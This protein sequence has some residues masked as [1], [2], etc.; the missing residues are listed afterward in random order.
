MRQRFK[1]IFARFFVAAACLLAVNMAGCSHPQVKADGTPE[2]VGIDE[3][4]SQGKRTM[5]IAAHPDDECFSGSILARSSIHYGNPLHMVV[6]TRGDGGECGLPGGCHPDTATVR[7]AEM[8]KVV[9]IYKSGLSQESFFN[10]PLP[11]ESFPKRHE[12]YERWKEHRDPVEYLVQEIRKFKP[13]VVFT[14]EPT[15][16]GTGHPEHQLVSR[17]ATT[18]IRQAADPAVSGGEPHKVERTYF[19][20]NRF[21]LFRMLGAAD[22]GPVSEVFDA[23]LPA[24]GKLS[25]VDFMAHA[26]TFHKTQANDMGTVRKGRIMFNNLPLRRVDPFTQSWD[27]AEKEGGK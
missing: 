8:Q 3:F 16:G 14:F 19:M 10:A 17:L 20:L 4:L 6:M 24:T 9:E 22:P 13:D 2:A 27:P 25:C 11:V 1:S 15:R 21:W 23:T 18:A 12:L 26:T 7:T 5:W